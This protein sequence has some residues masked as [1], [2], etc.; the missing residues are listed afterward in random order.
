ML[1][2]I[3][4][5]DTYLFRLINHARCSFLDYVLP[6]FSMHFSI[7]VVVVLIT[8]FAIKQNHF[9]KWYIYIAVIGLCFLFADRI[10][11]MCFK[12]VFQRL[13]PC[14]ALEDAYTLKIS[15]FHYIT[16][17]KGGLYGFVS[18]HA[19]NAFSII[20]AMSLIM[21]NNKCFKP[22]F[23][24]LLSWGVIT[25]YSRVY[26]GYHYPLDVICGTLLGILIGW[27]VYRIFMFADRK[28]KTIKTLKTE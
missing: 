26:C 9:K 10:S 4:F 18:S 25:G 3:L 2:K 12:D 19:A 24:S 6:V 11:V 7:G 21:K 15:H 22:F 8:F 5:W 27:F 28:I 16:T 20:T 17:N 13:R 23:I 14:Q 1:D